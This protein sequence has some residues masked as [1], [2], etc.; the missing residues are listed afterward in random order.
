MIRGSIVVAIGDIVVV[1][2]VSTTGIDL[3]LA[4]DLAAALLSYHPYLCVRHEAQSVA[5]KFDH[6][7]SVA[8]LTPGSAV[9]LLA[10][11]QSPVAS[12]SSATASSL[13]QALTAP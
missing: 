4:A 6:V 11:S 9:V 3:V 5:D 1:F 2:V 10:A 7:A 8:S 12:R 13:A